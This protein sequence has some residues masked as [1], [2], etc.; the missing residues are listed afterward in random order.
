M[1][2]KLCCVRPLPVCAC[3]TCAAP[4]QAFACFPVVLC[5]LEARLQGLEQKLAA[6]DEG[7]REL[8]MQSAA[9]WLGEL[10]GGGGGGQEEGGQGL[11]GGSS[12]GGT[13]HT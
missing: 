1:V 8:L 9:G 2:A 12:G 3:H 10:Q 13:A 4:A 11:A 5:R 6:L 7:S